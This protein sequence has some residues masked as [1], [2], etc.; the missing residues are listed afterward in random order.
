M[1][2]VGQSLLMSVWEMPGSSSLGEDY[3]LSNAWDL[4]GN[5]SSAVK[6]VPWRVGR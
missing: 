4:L 1:E 5:S 2:L 3:R 6:S